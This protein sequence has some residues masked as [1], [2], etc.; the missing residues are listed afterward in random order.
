[1]EGFDLK[2]PDLIGKDLWQM[3]EIA[4]YLFCAGMKIK[5]NGILIM[6]FFPGGGIYE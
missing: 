6:E 4:N 2:S 3:E 1:M 5:L